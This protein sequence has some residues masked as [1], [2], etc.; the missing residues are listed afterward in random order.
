MHL[1]VDGLTE[2]HIL[3]VRIGVVALKIDGARDE[4]VGVDGAAGDTDH[5]NVVKNR[6]DRKS[7][8]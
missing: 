6:L 4:L 7:V 3:E 5:G 1:L 8:V 2:D